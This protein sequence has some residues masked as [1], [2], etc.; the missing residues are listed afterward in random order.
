MD[1]CGKKRVLVLFGGQAD[2]HSISCIS[3]GSLLRALD[4][5]Q[6]E[7]VL[8]AITT[9]GQWIIPP[10]DPRNWSL[11]NGDMPRIE[12]RPDSSH[13]VIDISKKNEGFFVL[14]PQS[15]DSPDNKCLDASKL[16]SLGRIDVIFPVLHGIYGEDGA[17]Q[18]LLE[19]IGIP[20]VGCGVFASAACMD[21]HFTK[22]LLRAAN[23]PVTPSV[24]IDAR[25]LDDDSHFQKNKAELQKVVDK[26]GLTYPLFVKPAWGGSSFGVS[27]VDTPSD[28]PGALFAAYPHSWR[29]IIEQAIDGREIECSVLSCDPLSEPQVALPGEVVI[30]TQKI[31]NEAFYDFDA[32]YTDSQASHV[33]VPAHIS[34]EMIE[35]VQ[36]LA[37]LSFNAVDGRGL[38]R[39]DTFV[40]P[41][42]SVMVNEINTMPGFTSISM[43]PQAW[44]ASGIPY[45]EIIS[46]LIT[47][48]IEN[49]SLENKN[50][51]Q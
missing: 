12:N 22:T 40:C 45:K 31:N 13:V 9:D 47:S 18:G 29:I 38:M 43:Y 27:R 42:G 6:F 39:V 11:A 51:S 1:Q 49:S 19:S 37:R 32:K 17:I 50:K 28:L 20:Y 8:V 24:T 34:Q 15:N 36:E 33:E 4:R 14:P 44:A 46:R 41:D 25:L 35:K 23:I 7:P 30:D 3:A 10:E 2:E 48:T 16:R 5:E 21:K 26:A